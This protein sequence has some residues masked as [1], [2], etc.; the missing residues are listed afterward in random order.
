[1]L[2]LRLYVCSRY[3]ISRWRFDCWNAKDL[4]DLSHVEKDILLCVRGSKVVE[5]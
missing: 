2:E 4:S 5:G 1:M 3:K